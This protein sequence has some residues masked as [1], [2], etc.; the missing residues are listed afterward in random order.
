MI[1]EIKNLI[2]LGD[3]APGARLTLAQ[4]RRLGAGHAEHEGARHERIVE[5]V[6][7]LD[8]AIGVQLHRVNRRLVLVNG[9]DIGRVGRR[10]RHLGAE[11]ATGQR[12]V[13]A[14]RQNHSNLDSI[15]KQQ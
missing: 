14:T 2:S 15:V 12:Q 9:V 13:H 3:V 1:S 8:V 11:G 6:N 7:V 10:Q 5:R 4:R